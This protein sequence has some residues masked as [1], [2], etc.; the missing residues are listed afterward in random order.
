MGAPMTD[1]RHAHTLATPVLTRGDERP[2]PPCTNYP[3]VYDTLGG[4]S[5][6]DA[7]FEFLAAKTAARNL[8]G[9]CLLRTPDVARACIDGAR[10]GR[11]RWVKV[12]LGTPLKVATVRETCGTPAGYL[13]HLRQSE[14]ACPSC[15]AA[16]SERTGGRCGTAGGSRKHL[17]NGEDP[18]DKCRAAEAK[19]SAKR[20]AA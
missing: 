9:T 19:R 13:S 3:Q 5:R 7:R 18:C 8:C 11:E 17:R 4:S 14:V 10:A 16:E 1:R 12:I 6:G 2:A 20:R 15:R